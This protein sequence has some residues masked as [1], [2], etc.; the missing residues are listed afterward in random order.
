MGM[1]AFLEIPGVKGSALQ[2]HVKDQITVHGVVAEVRADLDWKTGRPVP[3]KSKHKPLVVTK[4]IDLAS[5][6]L[7]AALKLGTKFGHVVLRFW[8]MPPGGGREEAYYTIRL[9]DV[10]VVDIQLDMGNNRLPEN[11]LM[12]ELEHVSFSFTGISYAFAAAQKKEGTDPK[13]NAESGAMLADCEIP[14]LAKVKAM[15]IDAGKDA[16]KAVA[17]AIYDA[18]K[19][20]AEAPK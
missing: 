6:A 4:G 15:A 9:S 3:D 14:V 20:G 5:P 10:Q 8:R 18:F 11:D 2:T 7:H 12:P 17:G 1:N 16:G 19:G 13:E